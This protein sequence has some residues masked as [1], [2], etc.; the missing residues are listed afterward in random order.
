MYSKRYAEATKSQHSDPYVQSSYVLL[1]Y[2]EQTDQLQDPKQLIS[3]VQ[4]K[5]KLRQVVESLE[6]SELKQN[7]SL[8]LNYTNQSYAKAF[9][10]LVPFLQ[11]IH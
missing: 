6:D 5:D 1:S 3:V 4:D 11:S 10:G 7:L 8:Y 2:L 9:V